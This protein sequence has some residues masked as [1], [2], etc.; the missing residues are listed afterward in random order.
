MD[1]R[2]ERVRLTKRYP[3]TISRGTSTGSDNLFVFVSDGQH[4]GIGECAFGTGSDGD[5]SAWGEAQL[6]PIVEAGFHRRDVHACWQA[7]HDAGVDPAAAAALDTALWDLKGKQTGL[8]LYR[9]LGLPLPKVASSVTIGINPLDVI[10]DRVPEILSRTGARYLKVKLGNPDGTEADQASFEAAREA[11]APFRIGLRV[12]AN[13]G[14]SLET[15][16]T[17]ARWLSERGC[18]Y[19]EQPLAA[20]QEDELPA[21]F[22]DAPL[23]VFLDESVRTSHDVPAVADRCHGVNLKI[24][25]TGGVTEA[26][27]LVATARAHGLSTM[28]GCMSESSVAISTGAAI[29]ALFDHIDLDSH[30]NLAPDPASGADWKDGVVVPTDKPGHGAAL[31]A[32]DV[33]P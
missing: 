28:I 12:D 19:V 14:W 16:R 24:M 26:L 11:S 27:R 9:L 1:V 18:D 33:R 20:G 30:L 17:M 29:G 5:Q 6:A 23:P 31:K 8:P 3:L 10:R 22:H 15:A 4:E 21:L 25:K 7:M 2:F 13:G 32:V